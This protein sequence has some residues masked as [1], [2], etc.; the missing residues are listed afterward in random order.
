VSVLDLFQMLP[1]TLKGLNFSSIFNSAVSRSSRAAIC[2]IV[3]RPAF[4]LSDLSAR[5][6]EVFS[7]PQVLVPSG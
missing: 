1:L 4:F 3:H 5:N 2:V 7:I 6:D